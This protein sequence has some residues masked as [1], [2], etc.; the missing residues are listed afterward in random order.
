MPAITTFAIRTL[1]ADGRLGE[2]AAMA[3][4][5]IGEETGLHIRQVTINQDRYS[6]NSVNGTVYAGTG[7]RFFL[8]FT[9]KKTKARR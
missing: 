3:A 1:A 8:S 6:L 2:A 7:E 5:L 9:P 4:D